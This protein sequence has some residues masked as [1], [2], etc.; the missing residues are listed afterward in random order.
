[1]HVLAGLRATH[2]LAE[3]MKQLK[4]VSSKW[5]HE[6]LDLAGFAWQEGY[7]GFTVSASHLEKVRSYVLH[8][9]EHHRKKT[10]QQED[11]EMLERGLVEYDEKYLW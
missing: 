9:E 10:F 8:Q 1:V 2:C 6:E 3:V 7:G 4:G 5:V 11:V